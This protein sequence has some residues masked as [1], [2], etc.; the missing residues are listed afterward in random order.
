[1]GSGGR[2]V[3][4]SSA[5]VGIWPQHPRDTFEH[6]SDAVS[7]PGQVERSGSKN[8]SIGR[9]GAPPLFGILSVEELLEGGLRLN[10][11]ALHCYKEADR[12]CIGCLPMPDLFRALKR[13]SVFT[14]SEVDLR[15]LLECVRKE[16]VA[17]GFVCDDEF[18]AGFRTYCKWLVTGNGKITSVKTGFGQS[19]SD[20]PRQDPQANADA[21]QLPII[22]SGS[23]VSSARRTVAD[24][25]KPTARTRGGS[26]TSAGKLDLRRPKSCSV[27]AAPGTAMTRQHREARRAK[28]K[29]K[30]GRKLRSEQKGK[31]NLPA[32]SR[33]A[34][35]MIEYQK[36]ELEKAYD[37][38]ESAIH[39]KYVRSSSGVPQQLMVKGGTAKLVRSSSMQTYMS[40][41]DGMVIAEDGTVQYDDFIRHLRDRAPALAEQ[42][43]SMYDAIKRQSKKR[44]LQAL[45]GRHSAP[46]VWPSRPLWRCCTLAL[47]L[48]RSSL[49]W[50]CARSMMKARRHSAA[51]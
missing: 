51:C 49:C 44:H 40:V 14:F 11:I 22:D 29:D 33:K 47:H 2:D 5:A 8:F 50:L 28:R 1:M 26:E 25:E 20:R 17:S 43:G 21:L 41:F 24:M 10:E 7:G 16:G 46:R 19:R 38:L 37:A 35:T 15:Q 36:T 45:R 34:S 9:G 6:S 27:P 30:A 4:S 23:T 12:H 48:R 3:L 32:L 31:V 39:R 13:S 42:A 18:V